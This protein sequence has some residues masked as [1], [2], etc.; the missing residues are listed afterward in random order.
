MVAALEQPLAVRRDERQRV[1]FGR[2]DRLDDEV[3]GRRGDVPKAVLLPAADDG[4]YGLV[5]RDGRARGRERNSTTRA[6]RAAG[7]RPFR[8][9]A[10]TLAERRADPRQGLEAARAHERAAAPARE[11][12]TRQQEIEHTATVGRDE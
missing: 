3:R 12:A 7:D 8:G 4:S 9:A 5:V 1:C 6:F 11:A 2:R 10:A